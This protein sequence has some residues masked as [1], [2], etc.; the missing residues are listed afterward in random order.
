MSVKKTIPL[1]EI[2][3]IPR[4]LSKKATTSL[5]R[6]VSAIGR[7]LLAEA[8]SLSTS[9]NIKDTGA[10]AKGWKIVEFAKSVQLVNT[11]AYAGVIENGAKYKKTPPVKKLIPWVRRK[12][13]DVRA[14]E[15]RRIAFA[16]AKK[17]QKNGIEGKFILR[18]TIANTTART[19]AILEM[20]LRSGLK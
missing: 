17:I 20:A 2:T 16:I 13:P 1:S 18:Q 6:A 9:A 7:L 4:T 11:V 8:N 19:R 12:M 3:K 5:E 10:Y 15:R 14:I